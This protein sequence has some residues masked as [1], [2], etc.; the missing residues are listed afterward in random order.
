MFRFIL[1]LGCLVSVLGAPS[2]GAECRSADLVLHNGHIITMDSQ[3]S[4]VPALAIRDGRIEAIGS[5]TAVAACAGA[6]A[7]KIDLRGK[8]VLPGFIDVHT[9]AIIW[10]K[11]I[12]RGEVEVGYPAVHNISEI[13][14]ALA[15]RAGS[16]KPGDW[17]RGGGWDDSK[18]AEHRYLNKDDLEAAAPNIPVYLMHVSGHMV[19]A[20]RAALKAAGIDSKTP[21]PPGG[22][23]EH[24]AG[25]EPTGI[26]KDNAMHLVE[27]K[28]PADTD[29][30]GIDAV[31]V[32]SDQAA[33]VGLTTIHDI[34]PGGDLG[35]ENIRAYQDAYHR[36]LLKI[37]VQLA[38][39]VAN[40]AD[41]ER[42][43]QSGVHT[44]F[45]DD[46]V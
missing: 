21:D 31:K 3:R 38:P 42:L 46:H 7:R 32:V 8:T 20:S 34:W 33:A 23:I 35:A 12:A 43:A 44:G 1:G 16:T 14:A 28:L 25:G 41:A 11:S 10:A 37:R 27:V 4:V 18:L 6:A 13:Q 45:G 39:G 24:D 30:I 22:L 29:Q 26:L 15:K 19:V 40:M 5:E 36:G 9:H 2:V 17:I